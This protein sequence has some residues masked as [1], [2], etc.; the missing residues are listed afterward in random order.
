MAI[1]DFLRFFLAQCQDWHFWHSFDAVWHRFDTIWHW[2]V[3]FATREFPA[4]LQ[5]W[6]DLARFVTVFE[7]LIRRPWAESSKP[8][9]KA[10][11]SQAK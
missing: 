3:V 5:V 10:Q 7:Q 4:N 1:V 8:R 11:S 9:A 2:A 6:H